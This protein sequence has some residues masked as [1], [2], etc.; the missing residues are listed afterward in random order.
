MPQLLTNT[1]LSPVRYRK[2]NL[3][4]TEL[5]NINKPVP[6]LAAFST[7]FGVTIGLM[8]CFDIL[9]EVPGVEMA[10]RGVT[11]FAFPTNWG[12]ELPS[13]TG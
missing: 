9:F 7:D 11:H 8:T 4:G 10:R 3:F 1:S 12:D 13:L 2:Y 5:D 6:H